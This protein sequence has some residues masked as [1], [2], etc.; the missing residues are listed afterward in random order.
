MLG[1]PFTAPIP[2]FRILFF[3]SNCSG[4]KNFLILKDWKG[5][6]EGPPNIFRKKI[7]LTL[8]FELEKK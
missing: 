4:I 7:L 5:A 8:H 6:M 2:I 3:D 1:G